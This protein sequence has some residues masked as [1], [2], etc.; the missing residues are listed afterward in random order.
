MKAAREHIQEINRL[1]KA[2]HKSK[3]QYLKNDYSK[4]IHNM[5]KELKTYCGYRGYNYKE[6]M[7]GILQ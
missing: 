1:Y 3:S 6:L 4:R 2:M 5:K 7:K